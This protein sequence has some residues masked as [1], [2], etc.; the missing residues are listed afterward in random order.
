MPAIDSLTGIVEIVPGHY[1][2]EQIVEVPAGIDP[3]SDAVFVCKNGG[4][5]RFGDGCDVV[6]TR[7]HF[8]ETST[9]Q[10]LPFDH[11]YS[12]EPTE[13]P[14]WRPG[15]AAV[16]NGCQWSCYQNS[17]F[18]THGLNECTW[19]RDE[20]GRPC[21]MQ[22]MNGAGVDTQFQSKNGVV[23][24]LV[25][26]MGARQLATAEQGAVFQDLVIETE[27]PVWAEMTFAYP[28]Y[29]P[30]GADQYIYTYRG[31]K[32]D[33]VNV[34]NVRADVAPNLRADNILRLIDPI[35][36]IEKSRA[37]DTSPLEVYRSWSSVFFDAAT[38]QPVSDVR[39]IIRSG[40]TLTHDQ[41]SA[42]NAV[43]LLQFR[44]GVDSLTLETMPAYDISTIKYGYQPQATTLTVPDSTD[45]DVLKG[46]GLL[47]ADPYVTKDLAAAAATT[48]AA[49][50]SDLYDMIAYFRYTT[51][52]IP[53]AVKDYVTV[54]GGTLQ[55]GSASLYVGDFPTPV[56]YFDADYTTPD[57]QAVGEFSFAGYGSGAPTAISADTVLSFDRSEFPGYGSWGSQILKSVNV[58]DDGLSMI[59]AF[60]SG[61]D[62]G[63][64]LAQF[65]MSAAHDLT[66]ATK[67]GIV[68]LSGDA[69]GYG[70]ISLTHGQHVFIQSDS[71]GNWFY[72]KLTTPYDISAIE[73]TQSGT[74]NGWGQ[75]VGYHHAWSHDGTF[76]Y[77]FQDSSE[78]IYRR[79]QCS[80]PWDMTTAGSFSYRST[81]ISELSGEYVATM[82]GGSKYLRSQGISMVWIDDSTVFMASGATNKY[83]IVTVATPN[84]LEPADLD[85]AVYNDIP[86]PDGAGQHGFATLAVNHLYSWPPQ[87]EG[88]VTLNYYLDHATVD[89]SYELAGAPDSLFIRATGQITQGAFDTVETT[90]YFYEQGDASIGVPKIDANGV[91]TTVTVNGINAGTELRMYRV[92]DGA[93]IGGVENS[94]GSEAT[95]SYTYTTPEAMY[96]R[97]HHLDYVTSPSYIDFTTQGAPATLTVF[98]ALD[99][100]YKNP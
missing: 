52:D 55:F 49:T 44:Q 70:Y 86:S 45:I 34:V 92:S 89:S 27:Q 9:A 53:A 87:A 76:V 41:T 90:G 71:S 19:Q 68:K 94:T 11:Y 84:K 20:Y 15:S 5:V 58:S 82:A 74:G 62:G 1:D 13:Y 24:G 29:A 46:N 99:R 51:D 57:G 38:A 77:K 10:L 98:Q 91:Q 17:S 78:M 43:E 37:E 81:G 80:T 21:V 14:R 67:Q 83:T 56:Q 6:F 64:Y 36:R 59:M 79:A 28:E 4:L 23:D 33:A 61:S 3:V 65:S 31:L 69:G 54:S 50:T 18:D 60:Q 96:L 7:C 22:F 25:F 30:N 35:G 8:I 95:I 42:E 12:T 100:S 47:F 63:A 75:Y 93:E 2:V 39:S 32:A 85:N 48:E 73:T 66:T 97:V 88:A 40:D 72:Y 26:R 16:F